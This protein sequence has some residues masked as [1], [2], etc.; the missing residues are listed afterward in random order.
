MGQGI[1]KHKKPNIFCYRY[2]TNEEMSKLKI[3]CENSQSLLPIRTMG[4]YILYVNNFSIYLIYQIMEEIKKE[5][6]D[7][8]DPLR[9][10]LE[11]DVKKEIFEP[12]TAN[13]PDEIVIF[14]PKIE[15]TYSENENEDFF[16]EEEDFPLKKRYKSHKIK[17][18]VEILYPRCS[19]NT[20]E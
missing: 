17:P 11:K 15:K 5:Q 19:H 14:E 16:D 7:T 4:T 2:K 3:N 6:I 13:T 20:S 1:L 8:E 9:L 12:S 18:K 10:P